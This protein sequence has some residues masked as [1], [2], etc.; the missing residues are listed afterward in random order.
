MININTLHELNKIGIGADVSKLES[1]IVD[2]KQANMTCS[3]YAYEYDYL[4]MSKILRELKAESLAFT[5]KTALESLPTD[6]YDKLLLKYTHRNID[7]IYG[8]NDVYMEEVCNY[9]RKHDEE[10]IDIVAIPNILGISIRC[11]YIN[12]YLYRINIIGDGYKYTDITDR[13]RDKLPKYI[14]EFAK[15]NIVELRGVVT[16]FNNKPELQCEM[17]NVECSTMHFLKLGINND[18]M[19]IIID[20]LFIDTDIEMPYSTQWD[21]IEYIRNLGFN[22]PHHALIRNVECSMLKDAFSSF[23]EYFD[24]I[25]NTTGIAYKYR[26]YQIRDNSELSYENRYS[27]FIYIYDGCDYKQ[28]FMSKLKSVISTNNA[29]ANIYLRVLTTECNDSLHIDNILV[30]D[31]NILNTYNLKPGTDVFFFINNGKAELIKNRV[32]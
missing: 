25:E 20:D 5:D 32:K 15:H 2:Y 16:I 27:K 26:G 31:L 19:N 9:V 23:I 14:D 10:C 24:D 4:K 22:V 21:K 30:S 6:A 18:D 8:T 12:G 3:M 29:E 11:S 7:E 13:F 17:L 1:Y 28:I